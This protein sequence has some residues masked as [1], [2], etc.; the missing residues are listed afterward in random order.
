MNNAL[1]FL[2]GTYSGILIL[3]E[4]LAVYGMVPFLKGV[5]GQMLPMLGMAKQDNMRWVFSAGRT[6]FLKFYFLIADKIQNLLK[7][8]ATAQ[9]IEFA[10]S[11]PYF[12]YL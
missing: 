8:K 4:S 9:T 10:R 5:L 2:V 6:F 1:D 7:E 12:T 11:V 3:Y